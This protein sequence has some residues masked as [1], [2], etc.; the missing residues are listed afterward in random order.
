MGKVDLKDRME[1]PKPDVRVAIIG[2]T[3]QTFGGGNREEKS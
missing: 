3:T 2:H 1:L